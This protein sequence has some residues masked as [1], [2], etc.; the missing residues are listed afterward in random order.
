MKMKNVL[1]W[2]CIGAGC[3]IAAGCSDAP[4]GEAGSA[5]SPAPAAKVAEKRGSEETLPSEIAAVV[6]E[7]TRGESLESA[8]G[9]ALPRLVDLGAD[10]CIPC[11]KMA[12]ILEAL[13]EEYQGAVRVEFI[14]V[15]KNPEAGR[16]YRIRLIPTQIFYDAE[17]REVYRH[18][19]FL[20]REE[21]LKKFKEMGVAAP[22]QAAGE[23]R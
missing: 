4:P 21:I 7:G 23:A 3:L 8:K 16:L 15:W 9:K 6:E 13:R 19:G 10:R 11:K 18:E 17:G 22:F 2:I 12:P 14:D 20:S 1:M 5:G